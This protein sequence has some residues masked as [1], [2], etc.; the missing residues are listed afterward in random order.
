MATCSGSISSTLN[1]IQDTQEIEDILDTCL[2]YFLDSQIFD[3]IAEQRRWIRTTYFLS[4][5]SCPRRH[6]RYLKE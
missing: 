3:N 6:S 5:Q 2:S 1:E 4:V